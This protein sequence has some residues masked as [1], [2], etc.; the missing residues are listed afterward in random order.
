MFYWC[1]VFAGYLQSRDL[2]APELWPPLHLVE[3]RPVTEAGGVRRG[4]V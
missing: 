1:E 3:S 4:D 2:R